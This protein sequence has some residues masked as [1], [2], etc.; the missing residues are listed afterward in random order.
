MGVGETIAELD[1]GVD[2]EASQ[3]AVCQPYMD[4]FVCGGQHVSY[5]LD[6]Q[7]VPEVRDRFAQVT[8]QNTARNTAA[9]VHPIAAKVSVSRRENGSGFTQRSLDGNEFGLQLAERTAEAA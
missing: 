6:G 1:Y 3:R 5:F 8:S 4:S 2:V 9:A 7:V